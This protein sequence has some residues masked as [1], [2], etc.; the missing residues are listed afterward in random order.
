ML[1]IA[2][3]LTDKEAVL[4]L[5]RLAALDNAMSAVGPSR[6]QWQTTFLDLLYTMCTQV[7]PHHVSH[8][9]FG[10]RALLCV[11]FRCCGQSLVVIARGRHCLHA[12]AP[13][14][15]AHCHTHLCY[16]FFLSD[17]IRRLTT[18]CLTV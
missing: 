17:I 14:I 16:I 18:P 4:F 15:M 10:F 13:L 7:V 1:C 9:T 12:E 8:F 11:S 6:E 2:V 3:A 5:T